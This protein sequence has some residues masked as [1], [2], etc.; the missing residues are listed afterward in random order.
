MLI[1]LAS[2]YCANLDKN[3]ETAKNTNLILTIPIVCLNNFSIFKTNKKEE[4]EEIMG[5]MAIQR[6]TQDV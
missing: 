4:I 5:G 1:I 6:L 3:C 2:V